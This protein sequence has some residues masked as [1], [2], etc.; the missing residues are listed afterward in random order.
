MDD[1]L[2]ENK[3]LVEKGID[4]LPV[5]NESCFP[6]LSLTHRLYGVGICFAIGFILNFISMFAIAGLFLGKPAKFAILYTLGN[7][8]SLLGYY[9]LNIT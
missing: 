5:K 3:G 8:V 2:G 9:N 6:S 1:F 4:F 7:I